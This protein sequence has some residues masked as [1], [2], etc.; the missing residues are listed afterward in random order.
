M[1]VLQYT[2]YQSFLPRKIKNAIP[3]GQ[4]YRF[5]TLITNEESYIAE[6]AIFMYKLVFVKGYKV[7]MMQNDTLWKFLNKY[8]AT[9]TRTTPRPTC[10]SA[11]WRACVSRSASACPS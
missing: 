4:F 1:S 2:E 3:S 10:T 8:R 5:R 7:K 11:C 6:L 9:R